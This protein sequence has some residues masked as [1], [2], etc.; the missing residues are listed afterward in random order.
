MIISN[1]TA[2]AY[3]ESG[4][5]L[6]WTVPTPLGNFGPIAAYP[7]AVGLGDNPQILGRSFYVFFTYLPTD[8]TGWTHGAVRRLTLSC[9]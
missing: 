3:A 9:P 8:G 6:T 5:G 1:D 4:D 2:F 7:T